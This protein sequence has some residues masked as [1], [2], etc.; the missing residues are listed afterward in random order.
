[1][2]G[3]IAKKNGDIYAMVF[4]CIA[5]EEVITEKCLVFEEDLVASG[6]V[7]IALIYKTEFET[8]IGGKYEHVTN[9]NEALK[10]LKQIQLLR[11]LSVEKTQDLLQILKIEKYADKQIIVRQNNPGDSLF[12]IK[13]GKVDVYKDDQKIRAI[14]KH[15]YFGE[16]SVL[17]DDFRS[18]T[19]LASGEVN[20]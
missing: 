10:V 18:A 8:C 6:D 2:K 5:D 20:C 19:V 16:R 11:S 3:N 7:D 17:F 4:D 15:D 12:I 1:M 13:S 9:N 14:T